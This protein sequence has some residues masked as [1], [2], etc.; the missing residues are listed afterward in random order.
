[1]DTSSMAALGSKVGTKTN[2]PVDCRSLY[3]FYDNI[4]RMLPDGI[5]RKLQGFACNCPGQLFTL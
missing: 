4:S 3:I 5:E 1:M 2:I